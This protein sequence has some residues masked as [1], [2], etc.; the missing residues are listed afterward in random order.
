MEFNTPDGK[1]FILDECTYGINDY[2]GD[3]GLFIDIGAHV[4]A[5]SVAAFEKGFSEII[6]IEMDFENYKCLCS[7]IKNT[8]VL[9]IYG[10]LTSDLE[11]FYGRVPGG[12]SGQNALRCM[13]SK[14]QSPAIVPE[15]LFQISNYKHIDYLKLDIEGGEYYLDEDDLFKILSITKFLDMELHDVDFFT[16]LT[17]E[18]FTRAYMANL[19][20]EFGFK[21]DPVDAIMSRGAGR[22]LSYNH[23]IV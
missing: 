19:V 11:A 9:P 10:A 1:G 22:F 12:T 2:H 17:G 21:D 13:D 7:N 15:I 23:N 5:V 18:K 6:A 16:G 20:Y 14:F 8:N 4:G 3:L